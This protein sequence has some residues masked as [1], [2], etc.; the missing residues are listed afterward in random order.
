MDIEKARQRVAQLTLEL[1]NHNHRYYVLST[2]IITDFEFDAL[3]QTLAQ[4]E[5]QFPELKSPLSPT[6]RVGESKSDDFESVIHLRPM[7]SL[8]NSYNEEDLF[9]FDKSVKKILDQSLDSEIQYSC[10]LKFDGLSIS[11]HYENGMLQKAVTRGDGIAGDNVTENIKTIKSIPLQLHGTYPNSFE[12]RGEVYMPHPV[13]D[14]LN[15]QRAQN[16]EELLKNPRNAASGS[17]KIKNPKMVAQRKLDCF[18]YQ[19]L[20]DG[21]PFTTHIENL[22]A[23]K[24]W[25]FK[26]SEHSTVCKNINEV[27]DYIHLWDTKR[28]QLSYDT[29]GVVVKVNSLILQ[30]NLG[31]IAKSPR[32]AKAYKFKAEQAITQLLSISYQ[33]GRTGAI[34]PVANLSPVELGGTTIKRASLH[35]S[36]IIKKLDLKENDFVIIEKGGEIIPKIIAV[37]L[38]KRNSQQQSI[39]FITHC[40][41]CQAP[42]VKKDDEANHFCENELNCKPQ[43]LGKIE[44]FV[45]RK[46]MNIDSIGSETIEKLYQENLIKNYSHLYDLT[47]EQILTL[48][49]NAEKSANNLINGI[50]ES[51]NVPFDKVLF[52]IG[53]RHVGETTAKKIV[54][55]LASI[56]TI[57]QA[58]K[59][60]LLAID[61]V[62]EVI[63]DSIIQFFQNKNNVQIIDKLKRAGLQLELINTEDSQLSSKLNNCTFVISGVF[64]KYSRDEYKELIEK[65]GGKNVS[66]ISKKTSYLLAGANMGPEKLKKAEELKIPIINEAQFLE[67][68][69]K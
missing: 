13:F 48:N 44:H 38:S 59:E 17:I 19:V 42:L 14:A 9:E 4:I 24:T 61:E 68:I 30:K 33:V 32:W 66:S 12:I 56:N 55:K 21:L 26:V 49:A 18:L 37:D 5:N 8:D 40:P 35:N 43:V 63:A 23:S 57:M 54:K 52:A 3:L 53:I 7:L 20:G 64:E 1:N 67:L 65:N 15:K 41:E 34:T 2:P 46:A 10:E 11:L 39:S 36:D 22:K 29:D 31:F 25:G 28:T 60:E 45:S 6:Q 62:G 58:N 69:E 51:K 27:I 50:H 47:F 16:N